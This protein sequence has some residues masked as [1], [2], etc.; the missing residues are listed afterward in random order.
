MSLPPLSNGSR[1]SSATK[2]ISHNDAIVTQVTVTQFLQTQAYIIIYRKMDH[3]GGTGTN[4][5][6]MEGLGRTDPE[7]PGGDPPFELVHNPPSVE[8]ELG[9]S[10]NENTNFPQT[11]LTFLQLSQG[12]ME[13]L[14]SLLSELSGTPLTTEMICK[15]QC[16]LRKGSSSPCSNTTH[17]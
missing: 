11:M 7:E 16:P 8:V 12:R 15:T 4:G 17:N 2:W 14:T 6:R 1:S 10:V 5:P 3:D 13:E 9:Q